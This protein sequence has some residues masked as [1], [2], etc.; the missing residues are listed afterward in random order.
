LELGIPERK[1]DFRKVWYTN[2]KTKKIRK[3]I[4]DTEN[5]S[6]NALFDMHGDFENGPY[7]KLQRTRHAL[8]H[9][10]VNIRMFQESENEENMT[11]ETLV[12]RTLELAR[13]VRSAIIYLLYFVYVEERKKKAKSK[14]TATHI[15]AQE[16]PDGLKT[17]R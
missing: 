15:F 11:E 1:I 3:K 12:R 13:I 5:F 2:W 6:L 7:K 10:F 9:R 14:G 17:H 4:E 8:T 16:L